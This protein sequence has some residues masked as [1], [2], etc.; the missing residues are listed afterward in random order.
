MAGDESRDLKSQQDSRAD[1]EESPETPSF[2]ESLSAAARN[3]G[4]A[5]V[6]PGEA[7]SASALLAAIGGVRGLVESI[8][9]GLVFLVT[10]TITGQLLPSVLIP[11]GVAAVFVA[12]R[13]VARTPAV[14]AIAG[15]AGIGVSAALALLTGNVNDNFVPGL[16]INALS[17]TVFVVSVL[18]RWPLVGLIV[19]L[20]TGDV[21]EW[22]KD[23]AKLRVAYLTSGLWIGLFALRLGVQ[24]P[25]YLAEQTSVL[26]ATKL[27]MGVPLYAAVLWVTWLLVRTAYARPRPD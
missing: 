24:G 16:I 12:A 21:G 13:F 10:Y 15:V 17:L 25:L 2:R 5:K 11:I 22:R 4:I 18:A 3:A 27:I 19:A 23:S 9:P 8:A 7:P 6:Q 14:S 26:A 1:A 20:L